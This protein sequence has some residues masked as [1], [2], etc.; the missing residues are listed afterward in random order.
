MVSFSLRRLL[1]TIG[2]GTGR[3]PAVSDGRPEGAAG[4][5]VLFLPY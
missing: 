4:D 5:R 2:S 3:A 1:G